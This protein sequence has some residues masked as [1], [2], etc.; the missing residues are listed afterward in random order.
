MPGLDSRTASEMARR[1]I[2]TRRLNAL[3]KRLRELV[4]SGPDLSED[5]RDRLVGLLRASNGTAA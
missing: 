5:Q 2:Q 1:S 4:E 3:E